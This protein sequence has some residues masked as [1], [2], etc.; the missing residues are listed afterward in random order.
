MALCLADDPCK[1]RVVG[2][3]AGAHAARSSARHAGASGT[4]FQGCTAEANGERREAVLLQQ[5]PKLLTARDIMARRLITMRPDMD[6]LAAIR[7]LLRKRISG[8]PVLDEGGKLVGL[9]S[10]ADAIR[11]L[12]SDEYSNEDYEEAGVVE[13]FMTRDV[14]T[15]APD[16]DI[17]SIAVQFNDEGVRRMPVVE[18][19]QLVGQV[20]RRDVL[21]GI[22]EMLADRVR[23]IKAPEKTTKREPKLYLSATDS[24]PG[25]IASRLED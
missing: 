1:D 12:A 3:A 7:L 2:S 20:S 22:E 15:I 25:N 14:T 18:D 10:E 9:L 13:T 11:M 23:Q 16:L 4:R 5:H 17:Y 24:V 21:R 8:C 6:I 19:G